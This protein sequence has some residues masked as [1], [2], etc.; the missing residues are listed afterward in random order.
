LPE[1]QP[2]RNFVADIG[3]PNGL[4]TVQQECE[5]RIQ[6]FGEPRKQRKSD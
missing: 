2:L 1:N 5:R 3:G 4:R 6:Q